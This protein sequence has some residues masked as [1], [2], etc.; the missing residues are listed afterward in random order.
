MNWMGRL[1]CTESFLSCLGQVE[2][3]SSPSGRR[4]RKLLRPS[5][6]MCLNS[7]IS[8]C[9]LLQPKVRDWSV[10]WLYRRVDPK[11]PRRLVGLDFAEDLSPQNLYQLLQEHPS[12]NL[13]VA[14]SPKNTP[15]S[16]FAAEF[17]LG[18][19]LP[20]TPL[21]SHFPVRNTPHTT[22]FVNPPKKAHP[23]LSSKNLSPVVFEGQAHLL[24]DNPLLFPILNAPAESFSTDALEDRSADVLVEAADKGGEGLWAG[25]KMGLVTGFQ[26]TN[27]ARVAF[28]GG[29]KVLSDEFAKMEVA[30]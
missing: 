10:Y 13:L 29:V 6:T 20:N 23:L 1:L 28:V 5:Y 17:S 8:S 15:L 3:T 24:G 25:S 19:P 16:S 2:A 30:P 12:T 7:R 18:L 27:G 9:W 4:T 22:V 21:V 14:L 11:C 26:A